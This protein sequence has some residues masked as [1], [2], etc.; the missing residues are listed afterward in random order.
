VLDQLGDPG[1]IGHVG[2]AGRRAARLEPGC[3][4]YREREEDYRERE[5]DYREREVDEVEWQGGR[6]Y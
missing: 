6:V 3:E 5:E 2:A 4:D 1:R